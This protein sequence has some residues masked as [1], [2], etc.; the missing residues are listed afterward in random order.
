MEYEDPNP[1][2][3]VWYKLFGEKERRADV[4]HA[5][6]CASG[7]ENLR[8]IRPGVQI[9]RFRKCRDQ[10]AKVTGIAPQPDNAD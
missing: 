3:D 2:F 4:V 6:S 8:A 10:S 1:K 7:R 5:Y 9:F